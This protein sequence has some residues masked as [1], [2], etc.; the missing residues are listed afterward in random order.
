MTPAD[1]IVLALSTET[2]S[3]GI[4]Q[5][6]RLWSKAI[7]GQQVSNQYLDEAALEAVLIDILGIG[8]LPTYQFLYQQ[9]PSFEKFELFLRK[10]RVKLNKSPLI[11][12]TK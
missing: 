5:L 10:R 7:A 9:K 12:T 6:K 3:T 11:R 8:M 4:Y 2:G 1:N